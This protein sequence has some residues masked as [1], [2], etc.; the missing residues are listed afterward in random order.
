MAVGS[1]QISPSILSMKESRWTLDVCKS[2][3]EGTETSLKVAAFRKLDVAFDYCPKLKFFP[4]KHVSMFEPSRPTLCVSRFAHAF[5]VQIKFA[6]AMFQRWAPIGLVAVGRGRKV[7]FLH[8]YV[9][10]SVLPM[11]WTA[12]S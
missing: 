2:I 8:I 6:G 5:L 1:V 11:V 7:P 4:T 3:E 10:Q 9:P 12:V